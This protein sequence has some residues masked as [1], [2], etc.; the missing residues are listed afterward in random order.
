MASQ[1]LFQQYPPFPEDIDTFEV[2]RFSL[3]KLSSGD[4]AQSEELFHTCCN[5]GFFLLDLKDDEAGERLL[6]EI[7]FFF[8]TA[9]EVFNLKVEEKSRFARD[10][11]KGVFSR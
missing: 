11:S 7:E 9:K 3:A 8:G 5:F 2:P 1:K 10:V 4:Q 6:E